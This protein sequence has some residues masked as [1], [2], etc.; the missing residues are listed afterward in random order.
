MK[1]IFDFGN[2][3]QKCATYDGKNFHVEIFEN[4]SLKD[5]QKFIGNR[6]V[7]S[8]IISSVINYP[9]E[10]YN[11]LNKLSYC[12]EL[13]HNTPLPIK[14]L[15]HSPQSL[16]KDRLS[17]AIGA[18]SIFPNQ[19]VLSIDCGTA[20]KYDF[21]NQNSEYLGGGISPGLYLRFKALHTFTDKLPLVSYNLE[22]DLIGKDT[23]SAIQSGVM[24]GAIAEINGVIERYS[25]R[26]PDLKIVGTG[27]EM[28]YFEKSI[29]NSIFAEPNLVLTGLNQILRF[30]EENKFF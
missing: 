21:V 5:I 2:T 22:A 24:N 1:F 9:R 28:K 12:I 17:A 27:G 10:I 13:D 14:N 11:Y 26:Y 19:N 23:E 4:I 16:G 8:S 18:A 6:K 30:N 20:I 29:K 3:F 25:E 15:Y 7:H